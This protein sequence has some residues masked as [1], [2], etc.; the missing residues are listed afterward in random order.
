MVCEANGPGRD[1]A[2]VLVAVSNR[3]FKALRLCTTLLF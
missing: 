1:Q 3:I 2:W